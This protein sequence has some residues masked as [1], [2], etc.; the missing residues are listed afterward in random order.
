MIALYGARGL[1]GREQAWGLLE[2][3]ARLCWGWDSLPAAARGERG[4][5]WFPQAP[6]R[7]FNLSHSGA[8]A[9]CALGDGPVGADI[10]GLRPAWPERLVRRSCTEEELAWLAGRGR[11]R[12]DFAALWA[13][14]ES[15]GKQSGY[16]LPYPPS[17]L[18]APLPEG[19]GEFSPETLYRAGE[20]FLR[21]YAGEDWRG[22][23]CA[24]E[25]PPAEITWLELV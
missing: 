23:V 25:P 14:K 5:P 17:R 12:E 6:D 19:G 13:C 22:A 2:K 8:L 24:L 10:Q 1:T 3:A 9:L 16:G 20:R 15:M 11:E 18:A 7:H 4:K 21:V